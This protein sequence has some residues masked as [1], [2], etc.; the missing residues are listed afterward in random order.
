MDF[1]KKRLKDPYWPSSIKLQIV[2]VQPQW[3]V[4]RAFLELQIGTKQAYQG[5]SS[6]AI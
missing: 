2:E 1:Y 6:G 3:N 5:D 4:K